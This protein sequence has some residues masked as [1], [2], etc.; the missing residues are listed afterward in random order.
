MRF[1]IMKSRLRWGYL[2]GVAIEMC[3]RADVSGLRVVL[4]Y[5]NVQSELQGNNRTSST[6]VLFV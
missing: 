5:I 2:S 4:W 3:I 1:M 6:Y